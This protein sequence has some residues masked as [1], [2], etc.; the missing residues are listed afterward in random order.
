L[1]EQREVDV[2]AQ[3]DVEA[4]RQRGVLLRRAHDLLA[5][6]GQPTSEEVLIRHLFGANGGA[7]QAFWAI[8]LRQ[9]LA[10]SSLFVCSSTSELDANRF[11]SLAA[12]R[13]SQRSLEEAEFVV[14]DTETTGLRPGADRV[15][16]VAAVRLRAGEIVAS[17]Q[18]LLNPGRRIPPFITRFTGIAQE[19]VD[20][21]PS[22]REVLPRLLDFI[23][24]ATL[25]GHNVS[26]DINFLTQE[27][28]RL[29]LA[30]PPDGF[31]TILLARRFLPGLKRFK[32]DTV[33]EHLK[34]PTANRHRAMGDVK[35]TAAIFLRILDIARQQGFTS[36]GHLQ[37]R[38]QLPVAWSGDITGVAMTR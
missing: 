14:L 36:L 35:V 29:D 23:E 20:C 3:K 4:A 34:I 25:V 21:A 33:A 37:R 10:D 13:D 15:I 26:F 24:G 6:L 18:S 30:F 27:A 11:W 17:F 7:H 9:T 16:E 19:M 38:L 1:D 31:D 2:M 32:L 5:N 28:Y 12:W 8:L 22:A